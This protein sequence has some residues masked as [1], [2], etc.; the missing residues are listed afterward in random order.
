MSLDEKKFKEEMDIIIE[1]ILDQLKV[2]GEQNDFDIPVLIA[3]LEYVDVCMSK[4]CGY[5]KQY[6]RMTHEAALEYIY[7][8]E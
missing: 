1:L 6:K 5:S 3:S 2:L 7:G 4:A 8:D